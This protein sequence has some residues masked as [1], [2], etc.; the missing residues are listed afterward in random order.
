MECSAGFY[1]IGANA[2]TDDD[3]YLYADAHAD[4]HADEYADEYTV[5]H[6][7]QYPN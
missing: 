5:K 2:N 3:T 1:D 4:Q 6:A 7:D